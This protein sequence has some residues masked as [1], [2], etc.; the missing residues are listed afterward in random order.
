MRIFLNGIGPFG[1]DT[2]TRLQTEGHEIVAV[3]APAK[4]LSG[5]ADRL[6]AQAEA[7][8]IPV[9]EP[10]QLDQPA[11]LEALSQVAPELGVMAFVQVFI[12]AK[13]LE[14]PTHGTIQYHPSLLPQHRGR[15][16][17]NW[18]I[19]QGESK[20][21]IS[22]F[23]PDEGMD[24]GP[25]LLQREVEIGPSDTAGSLYYDKLYPLGI[26][27]LVDAV[28]LVVKGTA[29]K[30]QQDEATATYERPCED[31]N[32][33]IDWKRPLADVYNLIRGCDPSPGA[34]SEWKG[35]KLRFLDAASLPGRQAAPGVVSAIDDDGI[36]VGTADGAIRA[37]TLRLDSGAKPALEVAT[38]AGIVAGQQL[39]DA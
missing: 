39:Q 10:G 23:W 18:A 1:V 35:Q 31:R 8:G 37:R 30:T 34:W 26:D 29:P 15:S 6:W 33:G 5:R 38:E 16:A 36:L 20:T 24:T 3:A 13:A 19:I 14:L 9:F 28:E 27:A 22:I 4:S 17:I 25:V 12:K 32:S 11:V 2:L 7:A 21:G